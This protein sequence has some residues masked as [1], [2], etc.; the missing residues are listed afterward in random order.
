MSLDLRRSENFVGDFENAYQWYFDEAGGAIARRFLES[1]WR[2]MELLAL[3][4]GMGKARRF[5]HPELRGIRSYRVPP[6]F[7]AHLIFYRYSDKELSIERLMH[8]RRDLP[9]R[10]LE[11]PSTGG[12]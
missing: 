4:P 5:R 6:P 12:R 10:L 11:P 7:Q 2:A 9:R 8:G 1:V 3:R